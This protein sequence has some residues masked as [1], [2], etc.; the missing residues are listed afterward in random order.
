MLVNHRVHGDL[1]AYNILYYEGKIS[2]IDFP[3]VIDPDENR[4]AYAIFRRDIL[5]LCEYFQAQG[6]R[7]N[8]GRLADDLWQKHGYLVR[9]PADPRLVALEELDE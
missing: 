6:L 2:L 8:P 5:R 4:N 7:C 9:Q 3:Q 1:S